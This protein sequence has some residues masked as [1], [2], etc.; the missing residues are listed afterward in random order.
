MSLPNVLVCLCRACAVVQ[1]GA[2][3]SRWQGSS[4]GNMLYLIILC[5]IICLIKIIFLDGEKT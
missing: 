5:N 4:Y 2:L 1:A 3:A